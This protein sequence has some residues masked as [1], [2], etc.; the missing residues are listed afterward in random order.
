MRILVVSDTHG[1]ESNLRQAI[2]AQP[3][4][5]AVIHLGDG[6][7]EMERESRNFPEKTFLSVKGNCDLGSSQPKMGEFC[8]DGVKIFFTH[9]DLYGVKMGLYSIIS[10]AR[11]RKADVLLF[12]H[13][14]MPMSD[15]EDG[16]YIV[17][18]GSLHGYHATYSTLDI[19]PQGIVP[20]I[21]KLAY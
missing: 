11:E 19:T 20:N 8:A 7:E 21:V 3:S 4:A 12:G 13:T 9:G 16:L 17:N 5:E 18:P 10:A 14:H 2:L 6:D 15:Y 1:S